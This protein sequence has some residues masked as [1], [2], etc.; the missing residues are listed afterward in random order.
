MRQVARVGDIAVGTCFC[1]QTPI[2]VTGVIVN[3]S[4]VVFSNNKAVARLGDNVIF[5]CGHSGVI[6]SGSG[7]VFSDN[8]GV[9]HINDIVVGCMQ[10][11]IVS[12][13]GTVLAA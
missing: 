11:I 12:G 5:S 7:I 3:G 9:A 2:S 1:H 8:I 13:D 6:A 4:G 10:A